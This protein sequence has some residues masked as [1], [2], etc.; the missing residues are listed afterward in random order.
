MNNKKCKALRKRLGYNPNITRTDETSYD[1][2]DTS[3]LLAYTVAGVNPDGT[4]QYQPLTVNKAT[5][6]L[7]PDHIRSIYKQAKKEIK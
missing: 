5:F 2:K 3:E 4:P 6:T 7:K 1:V